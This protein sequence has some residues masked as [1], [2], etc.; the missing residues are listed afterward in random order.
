MP[1]VSDAV[2]PDAHTLSAFGLGQLPPD[3]RAAVEAHVANCEECCDKLSS[4]G[5]DSLV[6]LAREALAAGPISG[7][8]YGD[9]AA[10]A[11]PVAV[12]TSEAAVS[13]VPGTAGVPAPSV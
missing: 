6:G 2:H 5:P 4:V 11:K 9:E 13:G 7:T 1:A 3:E 8:I 10:P 12:E